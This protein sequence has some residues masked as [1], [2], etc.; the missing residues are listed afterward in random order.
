MFSRAPPAAGECDE[1]WSVTDKKTLIRSAGCQLNTAE[2]HDFLTVLNLRDV[3]FGTDTY[4]NTR[5]ALTE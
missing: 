5:C 2:A 1:D 3:S 4:T